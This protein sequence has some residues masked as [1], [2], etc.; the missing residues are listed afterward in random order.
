M[1]K[2]P[3][4]PQSPQICLP[5]PLTFVWHHAGAT[6]LGGNDKTRSEFCQI[7]ISCIEFSNEVQCL[8]YIIKNESE[9]FV[10]IVFT[11]SSKF[12]ADI[13]QLEQVKFLYVLSNDTITK[14]NV[15]KTGGVFA[16]EKDLLV[17]LS[18]DII[19]HYTQEENR[20]IEEYQQARKLCDFVKGL[21]ANN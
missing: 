3:T 8:N 1:S 15:V 18:N 7:V 10:L 17:H 4:S 16:S 12:L 21:L 19:Y 11:E 6:P 2:T 13:Q 9:H 20:R 14:R 5:P